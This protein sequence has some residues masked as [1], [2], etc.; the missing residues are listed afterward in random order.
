MK[1]LNSELN[2]KSFKIKLLQLFKKEYPLEFE[3]PEYK[4]LT[5]FNDVE[6]LFNLDSEND[7]KF[8]YF[9]KNRVH[10]ILYNSDKT[11]SIINNDSMTSLS[12]LFFFELLIKDSSNAINFSYP[13]DL[14]FKIDNNVKEL[15]INKY[16][17]KVLLASRAIINIINDYKCTETYYKEKDKKVE[18]DEIEHNYKEFIENNFHILKELNINYSV[19]DFVSDRIDKII[20]KIILDGLIKP[21][22]FGD[23][24]N[25]H[26]LAEEMD[27]ASFFITKTM[28]DDLY[29]ILTKEEYVKRYAI[30]NFNDLFIP[31]KI[32]FY[33]FLLKYIFKSQLYIY[34]IPFLLKTR[35]NILSII[36]HYSKLAISDR[37]KDSEVKDKI[38]YI[39][40]KLLDSDYYGNKYMAPSINDHLIEILYY[41]K[42]YLFETKKKE[43]SIIEKIL[44]N[45]I[46]DKNCDYLKDYETAKYKNSRLPL[47]LYLFDIKLDQE[48][49]NLSEENI[50]KFFEKYES[51]EKMI[52][53]RKYEKMN[54]DFKD[55]LLDYFMDESH[56][57]ILNNIFKKEDYKDFINANKKWNKE[58]EISK[59]YGIH[60]NVNEEKIIK[61]E[62]K[63][64]ENL[65]LITSS[66]DKSSLKSLSKSKNID[67]C[68]FQM[69][70]SNL[71][72]QSIYFQESS[73][74]INIDI[75]KTD[76]VEDVKKKEKEKEKEE[77]TDNILDIDSDSIDKV[78]NL[79]KKSSYYKILE[80][81]KNIGNHEMA[82]LVK[83][84]GK[85]KYLS[86]GTNRKIRIY[87]E[88]FDNKLDIDMKDWVY[89]TMEIKSDKEN[90]IKLLSCCNN[91]YI[92]SVIN[93]ENFKYI[94][95]KYHLPNISNKS[96][97]EA[98]KGFI[99]MGE[100][101]ILNFKNLFSNVNNN[102][103]VYYDKISSSYYRGG[104]QI[105]DSLYAFAS[106]SVIPN[107]ND[108][109]IIYNAKKKEIAK[110]IDKYS[111][112]VSSNGFCL[113]DNINNNNKM[114]L[115]ACRKYDS[116]QKNGIL[117]IKLEINKN[118]FQEV[119]Y[120]TGNFQVNCFCQICDVVNENVLGEDITQEENIR[121]DK[122]DFIFVGGF[123]E[124]KREGVIKLYKIIDDKLKFLQD[125]EFEYDQNFKGF[126]NSVSCITQSNI[127]GNILVT[128]WD[129][130]VYLLNPPNIDFYLKHEH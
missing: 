94:N 23:F 111:F 68:E 11:I 91:Y 50:N 25:I 80:V 70:E 123:D 16:N 37:I 110:S 15:I 8:L 112:I 127:T 118:N 22:K 77:E 107:G 72:I 87:D 59:S 128:C 14:I 75:N 58:I 67:M 7:L 109:L 102:P 108:I 64:E 6:Q 27:L 125:I 18:L 88:Y 66:R 119:F 52:K 76:L 43:I 49:L 17:I 89:D 129:G 86:A 41:Y 122:K 62:S 12:N 28:Y 71:I 114:L 46:A 13:M 55:K 105:S 35:K 63:I 57:Q 40:N 124:D 34:Q 115:W 47:I 74:M 84:I 103:I 54:L 99:T 98:G 79:F 26:N 101:G 61:K 2:K 100:N 51:L 104:I 130:N 93:T 38:A 33:Y 69:E 29:E 32:N 65:S 44:N 56:E 116:Q 113:I 126:D 30:S 24:E 20:I 1:N 21:N 106:N 5:H 60:K 121:I 117:S 48:K 31:F 45:E 78:K 9:N 10:P 53:D 85:G 90:E 42:N 3:L 92:V 120:D 19:K 4:L 73:S 96:V 36:K 39:L 97:L 95:T 83:N 81:N 82:D